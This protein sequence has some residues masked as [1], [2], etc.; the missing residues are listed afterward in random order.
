M[1][2]PEDV[3]SV[4]PPEYFEL[5]GVAHLSLISASSSTLLEDAIEVSLL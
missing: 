4:T 1:D 2:S 5:T 3:K